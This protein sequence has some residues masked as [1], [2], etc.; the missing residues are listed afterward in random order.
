MTP[1]EA[2]ERFA[3]ARVARLATADVP[4]KCFLS[5]G[6]ANLAVAKHP[7]CPSMKF[8]DVE[9]L[10]PPCHLVA[11]HAAEILGEIKNGAKRELAQGIL[12]R[13]VKLR[14]Q[15]PMVDSLGTALLTA[16]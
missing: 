8:L 1:A 11:D 13:I 15:Q 6:A 3:A 2:R 4:A 14:E 5:G 7:K 9:L 12:N 10:P 16:K